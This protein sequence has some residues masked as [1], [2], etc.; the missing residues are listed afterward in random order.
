MATNLCLAA[1][2]SWP[3]I[4]GEAFNLPPFSTKKS[5]IRCSSVPTRRHQLK[6]FQFNFP[7]SYTSSNAFIYCQNKNFSKKEHVPMNN[8]AFIIKFIRY[9]KSYFLYFFLIIIFYILFYFFNCYF[10]KSI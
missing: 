3:K 6:H 4:K 2:E 8:S 5:T 1:L 9:R 7:P 10:K